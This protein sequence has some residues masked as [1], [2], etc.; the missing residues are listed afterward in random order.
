M[1]KQILKAF[2]VLGI[3]SAASTALAVQSI[4]ATVTIG[5]GNTFSP[6]S[7]VGISIAS[8]ATAYTASSCHLNGTKMYGTVGG[9]GITG[10]TNN[11]P[12]KI[13]TTDRPSQATNATVC[14]PTAQ[15]TGVVLVGF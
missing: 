3:L 12:S 2:L 6:S 4:T 10:T 14:V 9:A 1:K 7:K 5:N 13:Y 8:I 11:D 15:T